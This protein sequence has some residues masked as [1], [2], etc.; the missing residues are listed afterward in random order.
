MTYTEARIKDPTTVLDSTTNLSGSLPDDLRKMRRH[1]VVGLVA[2]CITKYINLRVVS[3]RGMMRR[4]RFISPG[5][6]GIVNRENTGTS[7]EV[8]CV[9][10][11]RNYNT[12][13]NVD[14]HHHMDQVFHQ[15]A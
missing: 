8:F 5:L 6:D 14:T 11:L 7:G 4:T 2:S 13:S 10:A 15:S 3:D 12:I 1:W 9:L